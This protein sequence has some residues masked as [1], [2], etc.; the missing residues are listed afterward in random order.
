MHDL[1][2]VSL[3]DLVDHVC[4]DGSDYNDGLYGYVKGVLVTVNGETCLRLSYERND[5]DEPEFG[6][7]PTEYLFRLV[8][9]CSPTCL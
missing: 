6:H 9:D 8:S 3:V 5:G 2:P 7:A 1:V 4:D